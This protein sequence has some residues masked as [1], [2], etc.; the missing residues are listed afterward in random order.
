MGQALETQSAT[1]QSLRNYIGQLAPEKGERER[2]N[3]AVEVEAIYTVLIVMSI[4]Q[5][6]CMGL[7][8]VLFTRVKEEQ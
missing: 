3:E 2:L 6:K 7:S 5:S 4:L 8:N 1:L